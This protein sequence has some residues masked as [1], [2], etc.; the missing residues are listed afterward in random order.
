MIFNIHTDA[1]M[2][3]LPVLDSAYPKDVTI[4]ESASGSATFEV[5][6]TTEGKPAEYSYQWYLDGAVVSGETGST[7]TKT[8]LASAASHTVYCKITNKAGSVNSRTAALKVTSS[9]PVFTFTGSY[10][11]PIS[12][13]NYN[14]RLK[15][16]SSGVLTFTELGSMKNGIDVFCVG[17]GA[18]GANGHR[19]G[20]GGGYTK[21]GKNIAVSVGTPYT[22][23]VG[24]GGS[25]GVNGGE[26]SGFGVTA[27]GGYT[28]AGLNG[29]RGG[30]GG[31]GG[32]CDYGGRDAGG[33]GGSNGGNGEAGQS[34]SDSTG[35]WGGGSGGSGQGSTTGE[36]GDPNA[37][38]YAHGGGGASE[39]SSW[40]SSGTGTERI[41]GGGSGYGGSGGNGIVIIRN[42]R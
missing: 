13:G 8:G 34:Y 38:K 27:D 25:A 3:G 36:F 23:K 17:G 41:G 19:G 28:G 9:K 6:I 39:H 33:D 4:M 21:T 30:S 32:G 12:D 15:L 31:G 2:R 29:G 11:E 5:K 18:G 1:P 14:W 37:A 16:L 10:A 42:K 26:S 22:I 40:G 24:A 35:A 7:F 20:G